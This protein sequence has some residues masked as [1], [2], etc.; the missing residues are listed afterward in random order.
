MLWRQ[1]MLVDLKFFLCHICCINKY[2]GPDEIRTRDHLIKSHTREIMLAIPR[3]MLYCP[4]A[5]F[6]QAELPAR[7]S[8][9]DHERPGRDCHSKIIILLIWTRVEAVLPGNACWQGFMIVPAA[10]L[11]LRC[12]RLHYQGI[13]AKRHSYPSIDKFTLLVYSA[14]SKEGLLYIWFGISRGFINLADLCEFYL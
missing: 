6:Y 1:Y 14:L 3:Q 12:T 4:K 9:N 13:S 7:L 2:D 5:T 11:P 8:L 10:W